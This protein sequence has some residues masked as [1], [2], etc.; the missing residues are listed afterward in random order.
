MLEIIYTAAQAAFTFIQE[1]PPSVF[2]AAAVLL[3]IA[4][5]VRFYLPNFE[6]IHEYVVNL[7]R[8]RSLSDYGLALTALNKAVTAFNKTKKKVELKKMTKRKSGTTKLVSKKI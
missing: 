3:M 6:F 7:I 4:L 8:G 5:T 1:I 2:I